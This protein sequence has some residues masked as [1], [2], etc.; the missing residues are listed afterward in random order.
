MQKPQETWIRSLGGKDPL[1]EEMATHCNDFCWE[2]PMDRGAWWPAV[3]T[4]AKSW[5]WLSTQDTP[6]VQHHLLKN[7]HNKTISSSIYVGTFYEN[8]LTIYVWI[9]FWTHYSDPLICMSILLLI[10]YHLDYFIASLS[11]NALYFLD[12]TTNSADL[13]KHEQCELGVKFYLWQNEDYSPG[14]S[15]A[16]NS[17]KLL[18]R[19][20]SEGQYIC[21]FGKGEVHAINHIYFCRTL[22]LGFPCGSDGKESACNAGD[23]GSILGQKIP[24][25]RKWQSTP[26]FL[27]R[28]F[29]EQRNLVGYCPWGRKESDTTAPATNHEEQLSSWNI[30]VLF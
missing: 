12:G 14:D 6:M 15:L 22:L 17:K 21:D 20:R 13:M 30:L 18:Q 5:T 11:L 2:N 25:R 8:Q 4:V 16:D 28:E 3:H 1:E 27:P 26:V 23:S 7:N 19:D 24:W 9:Y 10:P 29:H